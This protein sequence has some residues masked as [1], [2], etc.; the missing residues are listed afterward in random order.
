VEKERWWMLTA[1]KIVVSVFKQPSC[2]LD[3]P[4]KKYRAIEKKNRISHDY[5]YTI[6]YVYYV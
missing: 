3:R 4:Q 5:I 2:F 6:Y 1:N